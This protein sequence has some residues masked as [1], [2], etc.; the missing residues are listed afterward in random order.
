MGATYTPN[1]AITYATPFVKGIPITAV[2][3]AACDFIQSY[4]WRYPVPWRWAMKALTPI[5]LV[6]G[7]QDY[8]IADSDYMQL[9]RARITRTDTTPNQNNDNLTLVHFLAPDIQ[10]NIDPMAVTSCSH[11]PTT[12]APLKLR[13]TR[14]VGVSAGTTYQINGEYKFAPTK[15]VSGNMAT[16]LAFQDHYFDIFCDGLLWRLYQLADDSR[17]GTMTVRND[18]TIAYSG[19][20]GVFINGL[21]A[22]AQAEDWGAGDTMYPE[23]PLGM[24][25]STYNIG[26]LGF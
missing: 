22:A 20:M 13:L 9:V 15:I 25:S 2:Q 21:M 18:G 14:S 3:S 4:I 19:Q 10:S 17:A 1:D 23:Q 8:T 12:A 11:V 24:S 5:A 16:V 26:I 6:N 7:T